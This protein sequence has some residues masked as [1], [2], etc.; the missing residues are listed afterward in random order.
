MD[1][2]GCPL[3]NLTANVNSTIMRLNDLVHNRQAKTRAVLC[4]ARAGEHEYGTGLGMGI[5]REIVRAHGGR[6]DVRSEVGRGTA[7][8]I[9]LPIAA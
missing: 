3:P 1:E 5:V 2:K 8:V 7:F 6:I 9:H 4:P